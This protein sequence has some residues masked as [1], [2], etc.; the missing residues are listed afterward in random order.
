MTDRHPF[1][2]MPVPF[3]VTPWLGKRNKHTYDFNR[4]EDALLASNEVEYK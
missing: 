2:M 1:E 4:S 3:P